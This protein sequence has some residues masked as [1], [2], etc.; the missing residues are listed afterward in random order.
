MLAESGVELYQEVNSSKRQFP[1]RRRCHFKK[2]MGLLNRKKQTKEG[3]I[4]Q[5]RQI[6]SEK[7]AALTTALEW[8]G[9]EKK[10]G[11]TIA[12]AAREADARYY[13]SRIQKII[14]RL[15]ELGVELRKLK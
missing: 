8:A 13:A 12:A 15:K 7:R 2:N 6:L 5:L 10:A 14:K 9:D 4:G 11:R 1:L 3:E